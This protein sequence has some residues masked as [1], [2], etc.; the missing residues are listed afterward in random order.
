MNPLKK[1][2]AILFA[3]TLCLTLTGAGLDRVPILPTRDFYINDGAGILSV[4]DRQRILAAA[5]ELYNETGVQAVVLTLIHDLDD[6]DAVSELASMIFSGWEIGGRDEGNG[7]LILISP[8]PVSALIHVG[9]G[10]SYALPPG[11]AQNIRDDILSAITGGTASK[12]VI[13][14]FK[15]VVLQIYSAH[16]MPPGE[17]TQALSKRGITFN[18]SYMLIL[19]V[20]VFVLGRY[21][22]IARKSRKYLYNNWSVRKRRGAGK[23]T[24]S[25][26]DFSQDT[27]YIYH[28]GHTPN[29][30][31]QI[32]V[33]PV[34]DETYL[35]STDGSSNTP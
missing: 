14:G 34:T 22:R 13:E 3:L 6:E 15:A 19:V 9:E 28:D 2:V 32:E 24:R 31:P 27:S 30:G 18:A 33:Y 1:R 10:L 21:I 12:G 5:T 35:D 8:D 16:D 7:V 20:I 29:P 26:I 25:R 23:T 17:L 11:Q 4:A